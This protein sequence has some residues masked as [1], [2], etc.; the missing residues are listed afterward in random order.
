MVRTEG[1]APPITRA[2]GERVGC[3]TTS[4][5]AALDAPRKYNRPGGA[6]TPG[7]RG[8]LFLADRPAR[9]VGGSCDQ[10]DTGYGE[11]GDHEGNSTHG[12]CP[13]CLL[14]G[15]APKGFGR[16][17]RATSRTERAQNWL[18]EWES[19]LHLAA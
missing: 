13:F 8:F 10:H 15:L 11:P 2:R 19:H 17:T 4:G 3:Y 14:G 6:R 9:A 18:P 5:E 12:R 7:R 16:S 1:L